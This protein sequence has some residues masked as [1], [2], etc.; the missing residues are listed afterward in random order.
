MIVLPD[1]DP[2]APAREKCL[3]ARIRRECTE[4]MLRNVLVPMLDASSCI[5]LRAIDWAVVNWSKKHNVMCQPTTATTKA[6]EFV[7]IHQS[8]KTM[9]TRWKRRLFD[10]FR[11]RTRVPVRIDD[12]VYET[13][14]GQLN[15]AMWM[16]TTGVYSYIRHHIED[17]ERDM[18]TVLH[19]HRERRHKNPRR[20]RTEITKTPNSV[21][22]AFITPQS[23][24]FG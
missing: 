5:S 3:V 11:R 10:P 22:V 1:A 2:T 16:Y 23:V 4:D 18:F 13:T 6:P 7:N 19:N 21:C 20:R 17:I 14:L 24:R 9:L 15:F 8:Y 12:T